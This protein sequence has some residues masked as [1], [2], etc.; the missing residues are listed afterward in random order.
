MVKYQA[1]G[2]GE[3]AAYAVRA[4]VFPLPP[5]SALRQTRVTTGM[6]RQEKEKGKEG[7]KPRME[8]RQLLLYCFVDLKRNR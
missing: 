2:A 3:L 7:E 8:K 4:S 5:L 1:L 6:G